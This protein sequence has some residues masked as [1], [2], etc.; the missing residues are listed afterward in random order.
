M[1]TKATDL[2]YSCTLAMFNYLKNS[3]LQ[4]L[5]NALIK[6][7]EYYQALHGKG[8]VIWFRFGSDD[9]LCTTISDIETA[10]CLPENHGNH[11]LMLEQF[12]M[13]CNSMDANLELE[14][15]FS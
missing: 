5:L 2:V 10:L 8:K 4:M 7:Q 6:A 13:V 1:T 9:T 15:Y 12:A 14:V 3:D 11:K